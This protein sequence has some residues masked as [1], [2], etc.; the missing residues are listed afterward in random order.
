MIVR[1]DDILISGLDDVDHLNNLQE[2]LT[3]LSAVGLCLHRSKCTFMAA[4]V[5]YCG[6]RV[7]S[8]GTRPNKENIEAIVSAPVTLV[9]GYVEFLQHGFAAPG[10][11]LGA[12]A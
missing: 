11:H 8:D 7:S 2:V 3:R 9:F 10:Y 12:T 6:R 1:M 5:L 4:E